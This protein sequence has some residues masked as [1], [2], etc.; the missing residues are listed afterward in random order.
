MATIVTRASKL[1]A[2]TTEEMDSNFI[3]LKTEVEQATSNISSIDVSG[4]IDAASGAATG[5]LSVENITATGEIEAVNL[6]NTVIRGKV[7]NLGDISGTVNIDTSL[8]DT[9]TCKITGNTTFTVSNLK[10]GSVNTIYLV[11]ENIGAGSIT[12]PGTTTFN[13]GAAIQTNLTG[14]TMI[15]LD[16]VDTGITYMGVQSWRDYA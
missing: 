13:R 11:I 9:V 1:A 10:A 16:T 6:L 14:K 3:N 7:Q 5:T 15:I 2:L 4:K 8:G 12:W